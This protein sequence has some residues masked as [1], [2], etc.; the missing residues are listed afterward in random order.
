MSVDVLKLKALENEAKEEARLAAEYA[1]RVW[2]ASEIKALADKIRSAGGDPAERL[3]MGRS[4][5]EIEQQAKAE[6]R[7]V[8]DLAPTFANLRAMLGEGAWI[9]PR[10]NIGLLMEWSRAMDAAARNTASQSVP[11]QKTFAEASLAWAGWCGPRGAVSNEVTLGVLYAAALPGWFHASAM[12]AV[13]LEG[14]WVTRVV[15]RG[16]DEEARNQ[17]MVRAQAERWQAVEDTWRLLAE[18]VRAGAKSLDDLPPMLDGMRWEPFPTD[19][20]PAPGLLAFTTRTRQVQRF[21][22]NRAKAEIE[23]AK[24]RAIAAVEGADP[25]R[26]RLAQGADPKTDPTILANGWKG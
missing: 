11:A 24:A 12:T 22:S 18:L 9:V 14:G 20:A 17:D 23:A 3:G 19:A 2:K 10:G 4:L 5:A 25:F 26:A 6:G 7:W 13:H 1:A 15:P 21:L 16:S 8:D